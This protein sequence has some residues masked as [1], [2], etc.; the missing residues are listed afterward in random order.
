[1][2]RRRLRDLRHSLQ[3]SLASNRHD[4]TPC[5]HAFM[6]GYAEVEEGTFGDAALRVELQL[7]DSELAEATQ[8]LQLQRGAFASE[9][10]SQDLQRA[11]RASK[12][13]LALQEL[14]AERKQMD[15]C[16]KQL[17]EETQ[18]AKKL[19]TLCA[20]MQ[21]KLDFRA[22]DAHEELQSSLAKEESLL[23]EAEEQLSFAMAKHDALSSSTQAPS[24]PKAPSSSK[25]KAMLLRG[26]EHLAEESVKQAQ[27]VT[28]KAERHLEDAFFRASAIAASTK[29][30]SSVRARRR[31][32]WD[33][34]VAQLLEALRE[35]EDVSL[36][37]LERQPRQPR[38]PQ[39]LQAL[40]APQAREVAMLRHSVSSELRLGFSTLARPEATVPFAQ[41]N[42]N[43]VLAAQS[44][45]S[46]HRLR[47]SQRDQELRF[48]CF[49]VQLASLG[50]AVV[51]LPY[52]RALPCCL[53]MSCCHP[54]A[55]LDLG[56][57]LET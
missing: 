31:N 35:V 11:E 16:H 5:L 55:L 47:R 2:T 21:A 57:Q 50:I 41:Q 43:C 12:V 53:A 14:E 1:M 46:E 25:A 20:E 33:A 10:S 27:V 30:L 26:A 51:T 49:A 38:Q 48:R 40:Q 44:I 29:A 22:A 19:E 39:A 9:V 4:M 52:L 54:N 17:E 6:D 45:C 36:Q 37:L 18:V 8:S 3:L 15:D 28:L 23:A 24:A 32:A 34:E 42:R 7:L 56:F 13:N